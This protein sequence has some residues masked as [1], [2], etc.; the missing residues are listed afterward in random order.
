VERLPK[1]HLAH[2]APV[3]F[4]HINM[5][6]KMHFALDDYAWLATQRGGKLTELE[7]HLISYAS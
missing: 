1:L 2:I 4:R 6:G 5:N 7:N 3:A